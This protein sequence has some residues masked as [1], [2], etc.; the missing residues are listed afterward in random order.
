MS[1]NLTSSSASQEIDV[2]EADNAKW[3]E[4]LEAT[5]E[6]LDAAEVGLDL[7]RRGVSL[8]SIPRPR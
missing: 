6:K 5:Q 3:Q 4:K 1:L 2:V 7:D 8:I